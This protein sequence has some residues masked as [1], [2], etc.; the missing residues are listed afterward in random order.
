MDDLLS[1]ADVMNLPKRKAAG[2][3]DTIEGVVRN[4]L[5]EWI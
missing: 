1:L 4:R 2:I 3:I 5:S